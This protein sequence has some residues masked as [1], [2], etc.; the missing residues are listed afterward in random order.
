MPFPEMPSESALS[1][2]EIGGRQERLSGPRED[3]TVN[4]R[5]AATLKRPGEQRV[6]MEDGK[7]QRGGSSKR[8]NSSGR[9]GF[10]LLLKM[11][12]NWMLQHLLEYPKGSAGDAGSQ[13]PGERLEEEQTRSDEGTGTTVVTAGRDAS[14]W[15]QLPA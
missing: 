13:R 7:C 15:Q 11:R 8:E 10:D 14:Q 2:G 4:G 5:K 3:L 9:N 1:C 12:P 6:R